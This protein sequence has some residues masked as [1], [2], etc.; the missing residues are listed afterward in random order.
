MQTWRFFNRGI[1]DV[2][3]LSFMKLL[4]CV[5]SFLAYF[6]TTVFYVLLTNHVLKT[7]QTVHPFTYDFLVLKPNRHSIE[8]L[9]TRRPCYRRERAAGVRHRFWWRR[10]CVWHR[11][12]QRDHHDPQATGPRDEESVQSRRRGNGPSQSTAATSLLY[13]PSKFINSYLLLSVLQVSKCIHECIWSVIRN[14]N[15]YI[16]PE[17]S[18]LFP[19][20]RIF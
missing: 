5:Y 17:H 2:V 9:K 14:L 4:P 16:R 18:G 11:Q 3:F 12:R 15:A 7:P 8:M 19:A 10:R 13:G 1:F 6:F 20:H